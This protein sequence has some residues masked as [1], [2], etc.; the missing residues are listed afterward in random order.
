MLSYIIIYE[1]KD[2]WA[3]I[4]VKIEEGIPEKIS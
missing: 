2:M 4:D 1:L 3:K